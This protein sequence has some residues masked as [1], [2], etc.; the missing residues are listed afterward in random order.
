MGNTRRAKRIR[1][2]GAACALAACLLLTPATSATAAPPS[3]QAQ[4][5]WFVGASARAPIP[6]S[7]VTEHLSAAA[8]SAVGGVDGFNKALVHI[9]KLTEQP[10][11]QA[12]P[13][14]VSALL[15][16]ADGTRLTVLAVDS[17]GL[18]TM[19][20]LAPIAKSWAEIDDEL[21]A[22]APEASF[23][24]AEIDSS[25]CRL[26]HGVN[27]DTA[28]PLGS[29]F[30]LYVLGALG[31]AVADHRLN[32]T[33][34]LAVNEDWKSLPSG[35]LQDRPAGTRLSLQE[36]ANYMISISD[37]TATDH[38]IHTIGRD[39]VAAQ[40]SR[41]GNADPQRNLPFL[42]TRELFALKG[43]S[44]PTA[45]N[46]YLA[47]PQPLRAAALP[48]L[49]AVPRDRITIWQRPE[50]IDTLEWFASPNDICRAYSGLW[51]ANSQPDG[52]GI[53][54]ALS[55][56]NSGIALPTS[57]YPTVWYKGGSEP[58]VLTLNYL[59]RTAG[60]KLLVTSVMLS[61]QQAELPAT[62]TLNA[63]GIAHAAIRL[64][65]QEVTR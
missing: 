55:I 5:S 30:K 35:V 18:I 12:S 21:R 32:W 34:Q 59:V 58:G 31:Q 6:E 62:T 4:L 11:A 40:L 16:S 7:E 49:D 47:L 65:D 44:Y 25:G 10:G 29:A 17:A 50:N 51:Q 14:A 41:F 20:Q 19:L 52:G 45:A 24:A 2:I 26:I 38:L 27:P 23:A 48:A 28:R 43:N 8:L 9:G 64:A 15:D 56:N 37:N 36:Y 61:D 1:R 46:A 3:A 39:A 33:D 42:T 54:T 22:A 63:V 57:Q 13:T 60:G 53:G